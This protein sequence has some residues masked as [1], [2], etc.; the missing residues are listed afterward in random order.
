MAGERESRPVRILR[1]LDCSPGPLSTSQIVDE[2]AEG[3]EPRQQALSW[4]GQ[5]LR[6]HAQEGKVEAAGKVRSERYHG[7]PTVLWRITDEGRKLLA[8]IDDAPRRKAAQEQASTE[9]AEAARMRAEALAEGVS[10]YSRDT[11]RPDRW[12]A[13][14]RLRQLGCTLEEIGHLFGVSREMIRQDLLLTE[15][16]AP[17][18]AKSPRPAKAAAAAC[19]PLGLSARQAEYLLD[20]IG[21]RRM[22]NYSH[23]ISTGRALVARGLIERGSGVRLTAEG[24]RV[25]E[26]LAAFTEVPDGQDA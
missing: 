9:L 14:R 1:A 2:L 20:L 8:Y 7:A 6:R 25:A 17:P 15:E 26:L 24:C 22:P 3:I 10:L 18:P 5:I 12:N 4:Y 13:A 11:P 16:P 21:K 19:P 23:F